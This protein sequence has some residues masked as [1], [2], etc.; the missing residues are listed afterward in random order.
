LLALPAEEQRD[1]VAAF[2]EAELACDNRDR[3]AILTGPG[4][5]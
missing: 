1:R 3:L 5:T 4:G 2:R